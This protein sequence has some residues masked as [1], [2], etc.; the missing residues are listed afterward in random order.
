[1][2]IKK[3]IENIRN[4]P[5]SHRIGMIASHLGIVRGSS[6]D[7][8]E[9]VGIDV[10]YDMAVV[11]DIREKIKAMPGIVEVIVETRD[12]ILDV[13]DEILLLAVGG[14]IRENVFAAL[15]EGV[16]LIKKK[17]S[18]KTEIFKD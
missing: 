5:D 4:H 6:R 12:G 11:E 7:G 10:I 8:G 17:G 13:G 3:A 16:N 2:D 18:R 14:D 9:V 15:M 1:M